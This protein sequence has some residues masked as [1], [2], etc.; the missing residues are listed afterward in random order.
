[1]K[2][3]KKF[4]SMY[5]WPIGAFALLLFVISAVYAISFYQRIGEYLTSVD[6]LA[7][8]ILSF[9]VFTVLVGVIVHANRVNVDRPFEGWSAEEIYNGNRIEWSL[10]VRDARSFDESN[11]ELW[12]FVKS[13]VSNYNLNVVAPYADAHDS[14][15]PWTIVQKERKLILVNIDKAMDQG[16]VESRNTPPDTGWILETRYQH[17]SVQVDLTPQEASELQKSKWQLWKLATFLLSDRNLKLLQPFAGN[18]QSRDP[19]LVVNAA[20]KTILIDFDKAIDLEH[21]KSR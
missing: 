6:W 8:N 4:L 12:K 17:K 16:H 21:V 13:L 11:F 14:D 15:D 5:R 9:L 18:Q 20:R 7:S 10:S 3:W 1:M 2:G 19:W